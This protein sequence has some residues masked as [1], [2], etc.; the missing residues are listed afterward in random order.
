MEVTGGYER[1][2]VNFLLS[3]GISVSVVNAKRIRDYAKA[4]MQNIIV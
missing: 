4:N 2:L 1:N 3:K